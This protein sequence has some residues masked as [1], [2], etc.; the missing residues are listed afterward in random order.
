MTGNELRG[1]LEDYIARYPSMGNSEVFITERRGRRVRGEPYKRY[2]IS[3][4]GYNSLISKEGL[5]IDIIKAET[6]S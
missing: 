6:E 4:I 2:G 3:G 1:A 5:S